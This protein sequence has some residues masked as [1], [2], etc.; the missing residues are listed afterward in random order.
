MTALLEYIDIHSKSS[1]GLSKS[2]PKD[3]CKC[4]QLP[5]CAVPYTITHL[6]CPATHT[7]LNGALQSTSVKTQ[8]F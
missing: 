5:Q 8:K 2:F 4:H 3:K 6:F 1:T 7:V